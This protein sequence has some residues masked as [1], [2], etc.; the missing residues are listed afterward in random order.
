M[1]KIS[2]I[3]R[4]AFLTAV[5]LLSYGYAEA[6]VSDAAQTGV[7]RLSLTL[8]DAVHF[9]L[10]NNVNVKLAKKSLGLLKAK[11]LFSWNGIS[12]SAAL[13]ADFSHFPE[14]EVQNVS[15]SGSVNLTLTA[16]LYSA[17]RGAKLEY[18]SGKISYA[19]TLRKIELNVRKTFYGLLYEKEN[20]ALQK[21]NLETSEAQYRQNQEKFKNGQIS[22]L[23]AF[24]SRVNYEQKKPEFEA[25]MVAF[26]NDLASLKQALGIAQDTELELQ[27]SLDEAVKLGSEQLK[28]RLATLGEGLTVQS[29]ERKLAAARNTLLSARL[30]AYS[31]TV[32]AG[33]SYGK[34]KNSKFDQWDETNRLSAGVT[35]PLD[36]WLPW[37][38]GALNIRAAKS[39]AESA[40]LE[41]E[42][43]RNGATVEKE[44]HIRKI[45]LLLSQISSVK[46]TAELAEETYRLS[47]TAYNYGKTDLS[48]LQTA[49]DRLLSAEVNLKSKLYALIGA[50]LE[51]EN[52]TG[53]DFGT[54]L[55]APAAR[56]V[57]TAAK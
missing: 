57:D 21:R 23:D 10:E 14:T 52:L 34:S 35:L 20:I 3:L 30:G 50:V 27:G 18:E 51:L 9:A 42:N 29:A 4:T 22:E 54:L 55:S 56:G 37:S 24:T 28:S 12:P 39:A 31:P 33:F 49:A 2:T 6:A 48:N 45:D 17:M 15:L 44:N 41:L 46:A 11:Q 32:S 19:Q 40:A 5:M 25:A 43:E 8:D 47:R 7:S 38:S 36:G 26:E 1:K 53:A 13:H 16:G